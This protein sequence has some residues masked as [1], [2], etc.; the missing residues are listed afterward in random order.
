LPVEAEDWQAIG[1]G[2]RGVL[3]WV[4]AQVPSETPGSSAW[5][6]HQAESAANPSVKLMLFARVD[7]QDHQ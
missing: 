1:K 7:Q 6:I 3:H 4:P 2:L 5:S